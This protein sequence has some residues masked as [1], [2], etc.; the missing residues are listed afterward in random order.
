[1]AKRL[2]SLILYDVEELS[3]VLHVTKYTIRNYLRQGKLKGRK[4][5][6]RWYVP[7]ISLREYFGERNPEV[8]QG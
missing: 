4:L 1:M 3:E 8:K 2:G 7:E 6:R 5:A